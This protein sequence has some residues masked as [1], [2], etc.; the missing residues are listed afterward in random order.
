MFFRIFQH[1]LPRS[2]AWNITHDTNLRKFFTGLSNAIGQPFKD[3]FDEIWNN[4]QPDT[5]SEISLWEKQFGLANTL[6]VEQDRRD[7]LNAAWKAI[8]GQSPRYIQDT[9]QSAGFNVYVHE[10]WV[11]GSEPALNTIAAATARNP[12][13]YLNDNVEYLKYLSCDGNPDS[14]DGDLVVGMDGVTLQPTGYPLVNKIFI[15]SPPFIC[16]GNPDSQDGDT[17][18]MDGG[19]V[20]GGLLYNLKKYTIDGI[21]TKYPYYLYIGGVTFPDHAII[22]SARRN[23]FETLCLKICPAHLWLGMLI[24]YS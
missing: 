18:T 21:T 14:Q 16:D 24:D 20:P 13:T 1:L 5:T 17:L 15:Y 22:S 6:T 3:F 12:L 8:G 10:W 19:I 9:L 2:R 4:I 7:R 23:E 11:P